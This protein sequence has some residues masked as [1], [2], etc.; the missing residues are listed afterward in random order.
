MCE[1][2]RIDVMEHMGLVNLWAVKYYPLCNAACGK[3]DLLQAG[4]IGLLKAR[5]TYC[6]GKGQWSTWAS[7]YIRNEIRAA[8]GI[9][10]EKIRIERLATSLDVPIG[11]G[12]FTLRDIL[13]AETKE[14]QDGM[15]RFE[16][17]GI[18]RE[19]VQELDDE[20]QRIAVQLLDLEEK[21]FQEAEK[22]SGIST[23][24]LRTAQGKA[25]FNLRRDEAIR[26][27]AEAYGIW[28]RGYDAQG[29]QSFSIT[30]ESVVEK[31]AFDRIDRQNRKRLGF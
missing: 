31:E 9:Q 22:E 19:R 8:L 4:T 21:S 29:W 14:V 1:K 6:E 2:K 10:G 5:D 25:Y 12:D 28:R 15:D 3:E 11:D 24:R 13:P 27:L 20:T 18:I 17:C 26:E 30:R 16:L 23:G 7:F